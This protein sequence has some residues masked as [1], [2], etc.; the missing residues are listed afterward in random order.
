MNLCPPEDQ[1]I[2]HCGQD[3]N[4]SIPLRWVAVISCK[5]GFQRLNPISLVTAAGFLFFQ[6][7]Q[8]A[9]FCYF[10]WSVSQTNREIAVKLGT[11]SLEPSKRWFVITLV[12]RDFS[13]S[14][15]RELTFFCNLHTTNYIWMNPSFTLCL[16]L[17]GEMVSIVSTHFRASTCRTALGTKSCWILLY[18]LCFIWNFILLNKPD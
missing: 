14:T 3:W 2:H 5:H 17:I 13:S 15:G 12:I 10:W 7:H 1:L 6:D 9:E 16:A 18:F 11:C 4:M 8:Q